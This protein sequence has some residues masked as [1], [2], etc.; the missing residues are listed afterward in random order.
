MTIADT[1]ANIAA[2]ALIGEDADHVA[3]DDGVA[4]PGDP[5]SDA[6]QRHSGNDLLRRDVQLELTQRVRPKNSAGAKSLEKPRFGAG[7]DGE[8]ASARH[9]RRAA[10]RCS[11]GQFELSAR[12]AAAIVVRRSERRAGWR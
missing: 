1:A 4:D 6:D 12:G 2:G 8:F 10:S 3:A 7:C 5:R 9:V 11:N